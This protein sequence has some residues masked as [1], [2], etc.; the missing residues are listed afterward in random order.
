MTFPKLCSDTCQLNAGMKHH[1][2]CSVAVPKA[3]AETACSQHRCGAGC[4]CM[5]PERRTWHKH[6]CVSTIILLCTSVSSWT[7]SGLRLH[8][9]TTFQVQTS[10]I[11]WQ[12]LFENADINISKY[13]I[14]ENFCI[15]YGKAIS[16]QNCYKCALYHVGMKHGS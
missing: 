10:T 4:N 14:Y 16:C 13:C 15:L 3:V 5:H 9:I 6:H 12:V 7:P 1:R 8:F 11:S 2:H